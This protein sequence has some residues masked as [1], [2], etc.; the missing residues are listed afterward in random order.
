ML[1]EFRILRMHKI[2]ISTKI[3]Y[4]KEQEK[5]KKCTK[6]Y[7]NLTGKFSLLVKKQT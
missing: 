2:S 7:K 3:K 6:E 4:T 5:K 1:K